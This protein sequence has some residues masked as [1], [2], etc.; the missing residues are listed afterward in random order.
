MEV[1]AVNSRIV[2]LDYIFS[3]LILR[4]DV[5]FIRK[6]T[7]HHYYMLQLVPSVDHKLFQTHLSFS[8]GFLGQNAL[9]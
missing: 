8:E 4:T 6:I 3:S 5:F 2:K 7:L 1:I 9:F